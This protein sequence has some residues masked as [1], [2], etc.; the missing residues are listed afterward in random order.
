MN[1][2]LFT[3]TYFPQI[4][5]VATS[6]H[7]LTQE[8]T[9]LGH[10]VYIFTPSDP[11]RKKTGENIISMKSMPCFFIKTYRIG[12]LY[13]PQKLID[14]KHLNLD[15]I[16]TQT[17]FSL[18]TFG[19]IIS[20]A[21]GI[22]MVHT[23]HTMYED[24]VHYIAGMTPAMAQS[25]SRIFCNSADAVIAPRQKVYDSLRSYGVCKNMSVIPTG[26]N[27]ERFH[28]SNYKREDVVALRKSYGLSKDTPVILIV[29]RIAMEKSIDF[30]FN[31]ASEIFKNIP[32]AKIVV[33][34]DGPYKKNLEE[35]SQ[36]LGISSSVIFTGAKPWKEV[37][38][39]YQLGDVFVS[40]SV[41]E[42]QGLTFAEAM[43]A[44]IPVVAKNDRCINGLIEDGKTG[45]LFD[46]K[47]EF[48]NKVIYVLKNKDTFEQLKKDALISASR[49]SSE[50]FGR[51]VESLYKTLIENPES[52]GR[53]ISKHYTHHSKH[54]IPKKIHI[55][56]GS[57]KYIK[58]IAIKPAGAV[59][60][61]V[62]RNI[63][64]E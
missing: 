4:N 46:T 51:S 59:I 13:S 64:G 3:D 1:I 5:G 14:I 26:I 44:S 21:L 39:Y 19:K 12:L 52:F 24:Y 60:K 53:A 25:I 36:K 22:P 20:K 40:A 45:F 16:H 9:K 63:R 37:G 41:S 32:D 35:L 61:Y 27:T 30:I 17:E 49:F 6:V 38:L 55:I 18:G 54:L 62:K 31:S 11:K 28:S 29:G 56:K 8:L 33:V 15:I 48:I 47:K 7:M 42:T 23:Y 43:S 57:K 50:S 2:G 58:R 34:G 10:N